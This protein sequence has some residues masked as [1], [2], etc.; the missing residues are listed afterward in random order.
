MVLLSIISF[1]VLAIYGIFF[2]AIAWGLSKKEESFPNGT[3]VSLSVIIPFR[4]EGENLAT[5]VKS[6]S[7]L[8]YNLNIVEFIFVDDHSS[9]NSI[10]ILRNALKST[11]LI[12]KII[13][14]S[15]SYS[16]KKR[17][18]ITGIE[19]AKNEYII[20][21]DADTI[22]AKSWLNAYARAFQT[23][24]AFI[25]GPV[26]N[27]KAYSFF[28]QLQNTEALLLSGVTIGSSSLNK[29]LLCSGANLG[30]TK[31][32]YHTIAPYT[33][34][35]NIASGDDLFF[36]DQVI[37]TEHRIAT[38]KGKDA[39]VFTQPNRQYSS[40]L[41]QAIRWSSKNKYLINK[42]NLYLSILIFSTN[43]LLYVNL[44]LALYGYVEA[45]L[46]LGIK[47]IIDLTLLSI[48]IHR[49]NQKYLI[50]NAPFIYMLYPIHLMI[51]FVSSFFIEV[52]WKGR[53]IS[54]NE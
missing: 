35:I 3:S 25:I 23:G 40:I 12:Y 22:H 7:R 29:P 36:L 26:I 18:L 53:M 13:K 42:S 46:F 2:S 32:L 4:N 24:A 47:F 10:E 30:Y 50:L 17:A 34:N 21:T 6:F 49:Y 48:L 54:V 19:N 45:A 16:G 43:I 38:L 37:N 33:N 1:S 52:K 44:F 5:I 8:S 9:D 15:P 39:L 41:K 11:N 27:K 28:Q 31:T 20:T 14:Q 51:I